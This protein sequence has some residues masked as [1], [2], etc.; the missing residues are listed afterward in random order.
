MNGRDFLRSARRLAAG[1]DEADWR[2]AVSRAYY[3]AFHV[4]RLLLED[5]HFTMPR[6]DKAHSFVYMRLHNCGDL[7][8]ATAGKHLG[9]LRDDRNRV[10]VLEM[11]QVEA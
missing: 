7:L 3:A 8:V 6:M 10:H 9:M 2:S 1:R 4:G 11:K 5:L